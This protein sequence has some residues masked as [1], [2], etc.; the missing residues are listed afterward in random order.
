MKRII[1]LI[2]AVTMCFARL[3]RYGLVLMKAIEE[4]FSTVNRSCL[5]TPVW[6]IRTN[7]YYKK[8]GYIAI[9]KEHT[10]DFD[11]VIYEKAL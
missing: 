7:N 8:C 4:R 6:N 1:T 3:I 5:D 2:I 9:G 11:L 10:Q